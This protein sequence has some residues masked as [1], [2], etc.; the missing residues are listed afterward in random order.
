MTVR[1]G[2]SVSGTFRDL[3]GLITM[4]R[5]DVCEW[6]WP[7][8]YSSHAEFSVVHCPSTMLWVR[9]N[10]WFFRFGPERLLKVYRF[11]INGIFQDLGKLDVRNKYLSVGW[12]KWC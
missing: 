5:R 7:V 8:H 2:I 10:S 4:A 11:L 1:S 9:W 6:L 12:N 3:Y